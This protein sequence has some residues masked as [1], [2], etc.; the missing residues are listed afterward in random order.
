MSRR[1]IKHYSPTCGHCKAAAPIWKQVANHYITLDVAGSSG[2]S[3]RELYGFEFASLNCLAYGDLCGSELQI[4]AYPTFAVYKDGAKVD[5]YTAPTNDYENLSKMVDKWLAVITKDKIAATTTMAAA[6]PPAAPN[7]R[8]ESLPL[9]AEAFTKL[10]TTTRDAWLVKFYA[11]WCGHCQAMAPAWAELGRE[12][13]GLLNI[14]E[15]NCEIDKRLC[16]DLRLR[17]YPTILY[18]QNGERVEYDGLR[19]F[20]DLVTFARQAVDSAVKEI[21]DVRFKELEKA[22]SVE[23]AFVYFYDHAA[24]SEDFEA[25]DR[26]TLNLIGHAPLYRTRDDDMA[27]RFRVYTR[28]KFMVVRDGRPSYYN[29]LAPHDLR[30]Y[31][32]V[33]AWMKSVW[34]PMVPELTAANSHEIMNRKIVVLG[35]L[36]RDRTDEFALARKELKEAAV[37]FMQQRQEEEHSERKRLR[38]QKQLRLEEAEDR[39]DDRGIRAAKGTRISTTERQEV[40]FAWV[41][42]VFWERWVR[43]TYGVNVNADGARIIINDEDVGWPSLPLLFALCSLFAL[44]LSLA[45][46]LPP[47]DPVLT[48]TDSGNNTGI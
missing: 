22:G 28:P 8:G 10:I 42:G 29:A 45:L 27:K 7:P 12:M 30:D 40:G 5:V 9:D 20:G 43:S 4:K 26:L 17:G 11:P 44:A 16:K 6:R 36:S 46:P 3:F 25:L 24:V 2:S 37:E 39:N 1:F 33:L 19:G 13:K 31:G 23:V 35:I 41:D 15:V 14:G 47:A 18:F 32:R 38:D 21:D 48:R 34:L